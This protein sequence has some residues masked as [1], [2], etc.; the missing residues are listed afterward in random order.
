VPALIAGAEEEVESSAHLLYLQVRNGRLRLRFHLDAALEP[1][2]HAFDVTF[3][4]ETPVEAP[5][6]APAV[7]SLDREY[8]LDVELP[9]GI[10]KRWEG[11]KVSQR[12]PYRMILRPGETTG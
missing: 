8:H 11:W 6:S 2:P 5:F 1:A 9:E 12:I 7:L 10:A 3:V 4:P